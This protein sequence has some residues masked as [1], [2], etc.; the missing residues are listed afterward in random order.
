MTNTIRNHSNNLSTTLTSNITNSATTI[1]LAS[2]TNAFGVTLTT[3]LASC[4][5]VPLTIDDGTNVEIVWAT[6]VSSLN[7][8][9][10]RGQEGSSGTAFSSGAAVE[11]RATAF[12]I[13]QA[14][15]WEPIQ[16]VVTSG[17]QASVAFTL[18]DGDYRIDMVKVQSNGSDDLS[19]QQGTGGTPTYQ[20]SSYYYC[21]VK[22]TY[23]AGDA[24][25]RASNA[26]QIKIC[27]SMTNTAAL[28]CSGYVEIRD[29]DTSA[30]KK[31]IRYDS[32]FESGTTWYAG[33]GSRDVA[34]AVTAIKFFFAG[35]AT[36]TDGS[37][38]ILSKRRK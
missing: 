11:C 38:F 1:P 26:S 14:S 37:K 31:T 36:F 8:T 33:A 2:V 9:V 27:P 20:T 30:T 23:S 25:N 21:G 24:G 18:V 10:I 29:V 32:Y 19:V 16:V 17:S 3:I 34:E 13:E 5:Y 15:Y 7:V 4:D 35:G 22:M 28:A 6:G 12:S